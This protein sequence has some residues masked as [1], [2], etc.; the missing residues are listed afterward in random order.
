M[1]KEII[2][3][4]LLL[5]I[6]TIIFN[7]KDKLSKIFNLIDKPDNK[8]KIHLKPTP[9][10]G[11]LII[12]IIILFNYNYFKIYLPKEELYVLFS[13]VFLYFSLS[14]IDDIKGLNSYFRLIFLFC[15]TYFILSYSD[16][17]VL[18]DLNFKFQSL[19]LSL[20]QLSI[21]ISTLCILLLVNALN[22][23]DG[24]N[25]LSILLIIFWT[26]YIKFFLF[27][28]YSYT[29][30]SSLIILIIMFFNIYNGEYFMGDYGV[31][32][33][34]MSIGLMS[35]AS[36]NLNLEKTNPVFV[37]E[38]FLLFFIPGLDMFRLFIERIMNKK[39]PFSA[40]KNHLHHFL[41]KKFNLNKSLGIYLIISFSPIF[42]FNFFNF[43]SLVLIILLTLFYFLIFN[44]KLKDILN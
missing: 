42:L 13:L 36:Y 10:L 5:I 40:D 29:G 3:L 26:I 32:V 35:I 16:I 38:I 34:A 23:S 43:N 9:L 24:I 22:L 27:N 37:E 30:I 4:A 14:I 39:D 15:G 2:L 19:D 8:R 21:F 20:N 7:Y 31:T 44:T 33:A 6:Y 28:D 11:G 17:F 1:I 41:I 12:L 18:K 25:G